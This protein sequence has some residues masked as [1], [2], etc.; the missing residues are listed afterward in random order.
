MNVLLDK[1]KNLVVTSA[2]PLYQRENLVDVLKFYIPNFY[3]DI[4]MEGF[5]WVLEYIDSN[6]VARAEPLEQVVDDTGAKLLYN[7]SHY[8]YTVPVTS[9]LSQFV[10]TFTIS[11]T[12]TWTDPDKLVPTGKVD[13]EGNPIMVNPQYVLH[14]GELDVTISKYGDY[15]A[16]AD[17]SLNALDKKLI[18][19]QQQIEIINHLYDTINASVPTDLSIDENNHL[20]L[21]VSGT[22][23]GQGQEIL[24]NFSDFDN[25]STDGVID[26]DDV[27]APEELPDI[28]DL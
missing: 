28:I 19:M 1:Y 5:L 22:N 26:L 11:L 24:I 17:D 14:T 13:E 12:G 10:G 25:D 4:P 23:I 7:D 9:Q 6:N 21:S 8:V 20:H 15:F 18:Q 27:P 2:S 3:N 16:T